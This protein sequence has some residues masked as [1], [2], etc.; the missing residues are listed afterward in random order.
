MSRATIGNLRRRVTLESQARAADGGGGVTLTW[1]PL[2]DVWAEI[3]NLGGGESF[4]A[5]GLQGKVSHQIIIRRRTDV[6]PAMRVRFGSRLFVI[7]AVLDRDG[8]DPHLRIL[9][10]ERNL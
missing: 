2:A 4:I 9:A 5:E 6:V 7:E 8:A 10:E 1:S 3:S